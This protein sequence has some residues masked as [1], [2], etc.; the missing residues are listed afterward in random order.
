[1]NNSDKGE[2]PKQETTSKYEYPIYYKVEYKNDREF[3]KCIRDIFQM[4]PHN[5]PV[6]LEEMD[7]E[8]KDELEYDE[9]A[10]C[11]VIDHIMEVTGK[12]PLF[13]ELYLLSAATIFS[14]EMIMGL[15][16][17]LSYDYLEHFHPILAIYMKPDL[18][19]FKDIMDDA[20]EKITLLK[21]KFTKK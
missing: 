18:Y 7:E 10:A 14:E 2:N 1:M 9:E 6:E 20:V 8:T 4:E 15:T 21:E 16:L 3:R 13:Q 19:K 17:L 12:D 5:Y 11:Q